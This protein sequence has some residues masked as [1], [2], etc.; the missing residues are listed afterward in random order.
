[1]DNFSIERV[2]WET[3]R[4]G[5][6]GADSKSVRE[7]S[8]VGSNPTVS[9]INARIAFDPGVSSIRDDFT[10]LKIKKMLLLLLSGIPLTLA[11]FCGIHLYTGSYQAK[12]D[13]MA[14]CYVSKHTENYEGLFL[15]ASHSTETLKGSSLDVVSLYGSEDLILNAEEYVLDGGCHAGFGSYGTQDGD[16]I[17]TITNEEQI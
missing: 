10:M 16:G 11:V 1:M 12:Q 3:Y 9:A 15:M 2:Y 8:H 6:N 14:A 13:A 4:S 7:K 5:H 17:P